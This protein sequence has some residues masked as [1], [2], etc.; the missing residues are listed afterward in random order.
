MPHQVTYDVV[1]TPIQPHN[2]W[3]V[4][5]M[6][7]S[8]HGQLQKNLID[9]IDFCNHFNSPTIYMQRNDKT[10][11]VCAFPTRSTFTNCSQLSNWLYLCRKGLNVNRSFFNRMVMRWRNSQPQNVCFKPFRKLN[12]CQACA[13]SECGCLDGDDGCELEM[14]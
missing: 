14:L 5:K 1:A 6:L 2:A 11:F 4:K 10:V 7:L 13:F 12:I 3:A 8:Y 9:L